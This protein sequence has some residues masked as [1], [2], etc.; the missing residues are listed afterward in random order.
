MRK[1]T[2][3]LVLKVVLFITLLFALLFV[4]PM[5]VLKTWGDQVVS[6]LPNLDDPRY[7]MLY[8][9][10]YA[11]ISSICSTILYMKVIKSGKYEKISLTSH[12][13]LLLLMTTSGFLLIIVSAMRISNS[14]D[15]IPKFFF[16][17]FL[18]SS[19]FFVSAASSFLTFQI[20]QKKIVFKF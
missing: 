1:A 11:T 18:L 4:V 3:H 7:V 14:S 13:V 17:C 6:L 12:A 8:S 2:K 9:Y 19:Y 10:T 15:N 20:A 5:L 16:L